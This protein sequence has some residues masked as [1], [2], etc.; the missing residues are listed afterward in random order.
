MY[1]RMVTAADYFL[2]ARMLSTE[3]KTDFT[4]LT[5]VSFLSLYRRFPAT[6]QQA[7][8]SSLLDS[9]LIRLKLILVRSS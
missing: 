9:S 6:D 5:V 8:T 3:L 1:L 2:L 7:K 4:F